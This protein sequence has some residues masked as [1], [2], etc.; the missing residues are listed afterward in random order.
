VFTRLLSAATLTLSSAGIGPVA[1]PLAPD[2]VRLPACAASLPSLTYRSPRP[3]VHSRPEPP[4]PRRSATSSSAMAG[5]Q[6]DEKAVSALLSA[7]ETNMNRL[8]RSI[9]GLRHIHNR[10]KDNNGISINLIAQLTA[11]KSNLGNMHDW[12]SHAVSETY[13]QLLSDLDVL[14]SSCALLAQ[15]LDVLV[16][17]MQQPDHVPLDYASRLKYVVGG[18]SMERLRKVAQGQ[19]EAVTLLLAACKW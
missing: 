16:E 9:D 4:S 15:H 7:V 10:W 3:S 12:L 19:N 6:T 14:M 5:S 1:I 8:R 2:L 11:L 13:P 18:R 17:R